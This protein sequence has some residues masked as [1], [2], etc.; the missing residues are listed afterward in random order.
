[1]TLLN[2]EAHESPTSVIYPNPLGKDV[3]V[4]LWAGEDFDRRWYASPVVLSRQPL[5]EKALIP[6]ARSILLN[7]PTKREQLRS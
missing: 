3:L 2:R 1:M 7:R 5:D 4:G 6:L